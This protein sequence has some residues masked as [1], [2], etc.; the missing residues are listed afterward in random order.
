MELISH[1]SVILSFLL[2]L[3]VFH[4]LFLLMDVCPFMDALR[5]SLQFL[6]VKSGK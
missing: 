6:L 2:Q 5:G 3:L 4:S 1:P